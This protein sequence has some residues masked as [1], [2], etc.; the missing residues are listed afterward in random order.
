M[1]KMKQ[2]LQKYGK[3]I[4]IILWVLVLLGGLFV[5]IR[6]YNAT[7][8]WYTTFTSVDKSFAVQ[9]PRTRD[10][11]LPKSDAWAIVASFVTNNDNL[12]TKS[13]TKPYINIAKGAVAGKLDDVYATT[14]TKYQKLFK[15]V[16]IISEGNERIN[17]ENGKK[18]VF[19][20][21]LGGRNMHYVIV[22]VPYQDTIYTLTAASAPEDATLLSKE[23]DTMLSTWKFL[24]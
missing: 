3:N 18:L 4:A 16:K 10:V 21:T 9:Y 11:Q 8:Q 5:L 13:N 6:K 19:E 14:V 20:G 7:Q 1:E 17:G 15:N 2:L 24:E 12:I 23:L 22:F